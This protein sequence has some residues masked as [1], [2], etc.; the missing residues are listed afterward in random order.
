MYKGFAGWRNGEQ[1][2]GTTAGGSTPGHE[3]QYKGTLAVR[4]AWPR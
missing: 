2:S 3:Y 1:G 4:W